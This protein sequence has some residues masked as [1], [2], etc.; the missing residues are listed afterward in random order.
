MFVLCL[1]VFE[2]EFFGVVMFDFVNF[3]FGILFLIIKSIVSFYLIIKIVFK[4]DN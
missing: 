1:V 3:V 2:V 4:N